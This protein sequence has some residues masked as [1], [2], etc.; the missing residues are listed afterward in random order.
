MVIDLGQNTF[1]LYLYA[2]I[3]DLDNSINGR[4]YFKSQLSNKLLEF[5]VISGTQD[6]FECDIIQKGDYI[7]I[8]GSTFDVFNNIDIVGYYNLI[9]EYYNDN[10]FIKY[11]TEFL[12]KVK[13][14]TYNNNDAT[15]DEGIKE[16]K[17]FN[18]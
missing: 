8:N 17:I 6:Y 9:I 1:K 7:E 2:N 12:I 14:S 16:Y 3:T 11:P 5:D 10:E 4:I 15:F 18:G 13:N